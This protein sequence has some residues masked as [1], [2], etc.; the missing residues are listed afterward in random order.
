MELKLPLNTSAN[1]AAVELQQPDFM[2]RLTIHPD[3]EPRYLELEALET[4]GIDSIHP[5]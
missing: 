1:I 3:V 4:T 2:G 5:E